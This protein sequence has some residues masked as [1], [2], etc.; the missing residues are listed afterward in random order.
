MHA[1]GVD[2]GGTK[3]AAGVVDPDGNVLRLVRHGTSSDDPAE[4]ERAVVDAVQE[5]RA[6]HEVGAVGVAA[7]GFVDAE[8]SRV[9]FAPNIAWR[10]HA[11]RDSLATHIDLPIVVENDANAAGWAEFRFGAG[12]D[13]EHMV[14][15]TVGTGLGGAIV[16]GGSLLRGAFGA[17]GEVGHMQLVPDG[18]L[19]GCGHAGCWEQYA[20]GRALVR[21]TKA[22][23]V[24][25][26]ER[27]DALLRLAGG[28]PE[29]VTGPHVTEAARAGDPLALELLEDLG[30]ALGTGI[31]DLAALLDPEV[32]VVG[33]G[34][35]DAGDLLLAP[36]RR[37]FTEQLFARGFRPEPVIV[38]ARLGNDAGVVGVAD[39]AR[40]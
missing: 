6:E 16:T 35:A 9:R 29:D 15:L 34:V 4:I 22:A 14:L 32:V 37:A 18:Q 24:T 40:G 21:D 8:R 27:A 10:D 39:L 3:I 7:A 38:T 25:T 28:D 2:I 33:G 31:A 1:I 11:L 36:A 23:L 20:S 13:A 5:L 30:A 26:P 19:C 17:A 12:R